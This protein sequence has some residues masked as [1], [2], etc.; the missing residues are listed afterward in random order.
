MTKAERIFNDSY[1]EAKRHIRIWGV[2]YNP[3]GKIVGFNRLMTNDNDF[4]C[5]RTLNAIVKLVAQKRKQFKMQ[6]EFNIE[7][8]NNNELALDMIEVTIE[9]ERKLLEELKNF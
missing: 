4:M 3:N 6:K 8:D 7:V 9:Y 2:K 1:F 5:T